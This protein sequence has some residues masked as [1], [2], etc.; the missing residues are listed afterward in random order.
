MINLRPNGV[1]LERNQ[2]PAMAFAPGKVK[3]TKGFP[4]EIMEGLREELALSGSGHTA[5]GLVCQGSRSP[6]VMSPGWVGGSRMSVAIPFGPGKPDRGFPCE[7]TV[8][9]S[10]HSGFSVP[11]P[12]C[13][14]HMDNDF[15]PVM[16]PAGFKPATH[17]FAVAFRIKSFQPLTAFPRGCV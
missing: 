12:D 17:G 2:V 7:A 3:K 6:S 4:S 1:T 10:Q 9:A 15:I 14:S 16:R 13:S 5:W 8:R 11:S